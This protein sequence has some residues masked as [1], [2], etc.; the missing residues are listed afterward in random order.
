MALPVAL[1]QFPVHLGSLQSATGE[2]KQ[3]Q[4]LEIEKTNQ[5]GGGALCDLAAGTQLATTGSFTIA[6]ITSK[7]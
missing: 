3:T 7:P 2:K 1:L 4:R 5:A 6:I